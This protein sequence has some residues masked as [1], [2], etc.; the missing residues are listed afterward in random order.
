MRV[1]TLEVEQRWKG[2]VEKTIQIETCE[3]CTTGVAFEVGDRWV[4][5]ADGQPSTTSDCGR[6]LQY[7]DVRYPAVV[8]WLKTKAAKPLRRAP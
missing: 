2:P 7:S 8:E 1:A 5:F 4:V 6:T 3:Q